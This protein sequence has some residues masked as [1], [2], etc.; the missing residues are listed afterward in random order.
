MTLF[1]WEHYP[2]RNE[3]IQESCHGTGGTV[4][5]YCLCL[6]YVPTAPTVDISQVPN[7]SSYVALFLAQKPTYFDKQRTPLHEQCQALFEG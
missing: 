7:R 4:C 3:V 6:L 2:L 5:A 1:F